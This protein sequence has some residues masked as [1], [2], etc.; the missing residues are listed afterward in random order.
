MAKP[1]VIVHGPQACGKT[2]NGAAIAKKLGLAKVVELDDWPFSTKPPREGA[3]L[4]TNRTPMEL[5][6]Y[7]L[8]LMPYAE[9]MKQ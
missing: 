7:E 9:A 4:L 6:K 1:S 8:T 5:A 2:R 3:V